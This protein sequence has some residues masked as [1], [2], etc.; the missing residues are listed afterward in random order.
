MKPTGE[1]LIFGIIAVIILWD[2]KT[3]LMSL[4][5]AKRLKKGVKKYEQRLRY[6]V[7][8]WGNR[9]V[10]TIGYKEISELA[11]DLQEKGLSSKYRHDIIA[12]L[13]TFYRWLWKTG[14]IRLDQIPNF[15]TVKYSMA[16]RQIVAKGYSISDH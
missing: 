10:K 15:P 2:L 8:A 16:F 11:T 4:S 13:K 5:I 14:E 12:V 1:H 6:A 3:R 9:N 7:D